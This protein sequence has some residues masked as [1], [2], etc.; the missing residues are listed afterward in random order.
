M[1]TLISKINPIVLGLLT[2][3][4]FS[5]SLL[6]AQTEKQIHVEVFDKD[7][8]KPINKAEVIIYSRD[9]FTFDNYTDDRGRFSTEPSSRLVSGEIIKIQ[10]VKGGY[11]RKSL[12]KT[13]GS[14]LSSNHF[15]I[16]LKPQ[17]SKSVFLT[18]TVR[19][20]SDRNFIE[21][22]KIE[23]MSREGRLETSTDEFGLFI[24]EIP[25]S[26]LFDIESN[27]I[28]LNFLYIGYRNVSMDFPIPRSG[29]ARLKDIYL[30]KKTNSSPLKYIPGASIAIQF[31]QGH[32]KRGHL[33]LW[34]AVVSSGFTI[35]SHHF[36]QYYLA[37]TFAA[38]NNGNSASYMSQRN[39]WETLR[40]TSI[41]LGISFLVVSIIDANI[42]EQKFT[43]RTNHSSVKVAFNS[44]NGIGLCLNINF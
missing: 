17:K 30:K 29:N 9:F 44:Q 35:L 37:Q 23:Y 14:T 32:Q 40:N 5:L 7:T 36:Y 24:F 26:I 18:G 28:T 10:V 2:L 19:N 42:S 39:T 21:G 43:N 25:E 13:I 1:S 8:D 41:G 34:G 6:S 16:S 20:D 22:V 33:Y 38:I 11:E 31:K 3:L 15:E 27:A 12:I 4:N